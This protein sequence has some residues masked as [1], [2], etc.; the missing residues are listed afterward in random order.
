MKISV[1]QLRQII[2]ETVRSRRLNEAVPPPKPLTIDANDLS[3]EKDDE[4]E[5]VLTGRFSDYGITRDN[6]PGTIIVKEPTGKD[7]TTFKK[8]VTHRMEGNAVEVIYTAPGDHKLRMIAYSDAEYTDDSLEYA[9]MQRELT[10]AMLY[11]WDELMAKFPGLEDA[12][13]AV[14]KK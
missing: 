14:S 13:R 2:R 4:G 7:T 12:L 1:K 3:Y 6:V 11:N 9:K 10:N 8:L 5:D